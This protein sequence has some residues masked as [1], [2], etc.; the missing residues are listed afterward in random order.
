M[1]QINIDEK[2]L[3]A[4]T[5]REREIIKDMADGLTCRQSARRRSIS[6]RTVEVHRHNIFKKTGLSRAT[7]V[8]A[9]FIRGG[10]I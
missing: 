10:I 8:V 6:R 9:A 7:E 5:N 2:L 1:N 4:V 3:Q